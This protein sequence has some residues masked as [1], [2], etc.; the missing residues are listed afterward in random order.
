MVMSRLY[1][2]G[3]EAQPGI[4]VELARKTIPQV[5]PQSYYGA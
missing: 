5:E 4:A 3:N 1:P 2:V